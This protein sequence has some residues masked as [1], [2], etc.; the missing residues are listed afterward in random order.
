MRP[1]A[2]LLH[3]SVLVSNLARSAQVYDR[4]HH[5]SSNF[6]LAVANARHLGHAAERAIVGFAQRRESQKAQSRAGFDGF[7]S[8]STYRTPPRIDIW[9]YDT[10]ADPRSDRI[11]YS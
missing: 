6:R 10:P 8:A 4:S 11:Y 3:R 2:G 1:R 5:P 9:E 7:Q